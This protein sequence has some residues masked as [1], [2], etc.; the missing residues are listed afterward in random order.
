MFTYTADF[1]TGGTAGK[2]KL[3]VGESAEI[4]ESVLPLNVYVCPDCGK[5]ELF[6]GDAI[7]DS[8]LRIADKRK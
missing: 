6:A 2:W 5:V 8:L 4:G 1:R 3:L 7:K